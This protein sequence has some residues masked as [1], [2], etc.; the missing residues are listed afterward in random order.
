MYNIELSEIINTSNVVTIIRT[1]DTRV[2]FTGLQPATLYTVTIA[3]V[4]L[5]TMVD[6]VLYFTQTLDNGE[7]DI[8]MMSLHQSHLC[9]SDR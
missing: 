7:Y 1:N 2:H 6:T 3:P 5:G 8:M 9:Y 4:I